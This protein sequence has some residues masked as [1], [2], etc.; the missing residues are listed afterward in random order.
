LR[1]IVFVLSFA[2]L[3]GQHLAAQVDTSTKC[4]NNSS[5]SC[6]LTNV[7]GKN[8]LTLPN[9]THQAHFDNAFLANFSPLN[10]AIATELT[11]LPLASPASGFT[12]T[13]DRASGI[14]TRSAQSF[15]PILAERAETMGKGKV[16]LGFTYQYFTFDNLDGINLGDVPAVYKHIFITGQ[17]FENDFVTTSNNLDLT[18]GQVTGFAT[19]GITNRIDVSLAVPVLH[20]RFGVNS[21]ATIHRTSA[22]DPNLPPVH[23]FDPNDINNS[24]KANF[25]DHGS[26]TGI[27]DVT[28]RLKGTL[29]RSPHAALA[30]AT[31]LRMP[32]GDE[33]N[34]LGSGTFGVRPF[35]IGS[36]T[37]GRVAP[38]LNIGYQINGSSLLAGDI[39]RNTKGHLP[40]SFFYTVGADVGAGKHLTLAFDLLGQRVFN[41]T[42]VL[43]DQPYTTPYK[44]LAEPGVTAQA[45]YQQITNRHASYNLVAGAVGLKAQLVGKV[46][47]TTNFLFALNNNGL[48]AKVVPLVGLSYTF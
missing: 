16:F 13:F 40:N 22:N 27:G 35:L 47:L 33:Q 25:A 46:L 14:Y 30:L 18:V 34:F 15:G 19:V 2:S 6:L 5:L 45:S 36:I 43:L 24:V 3:C 4:S 23:Y 1:R 31:D 8:G 12:Y 17:G 7:Y 37:A 9:P 32:T 38:H 41:G 26:A 21:A 42:R 28:L 11:L 44:E 48:H 20:V 39:S 29:V 10:T